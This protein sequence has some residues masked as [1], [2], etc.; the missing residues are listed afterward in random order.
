MNHFG[1]G[2]TLTEKGEYQFTVI[3]KV[4]GVPKS[5]QFKYTVK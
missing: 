2:L 4:D 3:V 5:T 1:D